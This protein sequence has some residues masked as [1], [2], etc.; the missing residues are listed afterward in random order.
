MA[1]LITGLAS[2]VQAK[3]NAKWLIGRSEM[4]L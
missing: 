3:G 2:S 4:M 1:D